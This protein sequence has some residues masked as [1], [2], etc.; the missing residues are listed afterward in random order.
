LTTHFG[1]NRARA[2]AIFEVVANKCLA[3]SPKPRLSGGLSR[4]QTLA[5]FAAD[6]KLAHEARSGNQLSIH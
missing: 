4:F 6:M 3:V 1:K 2:D 5:L